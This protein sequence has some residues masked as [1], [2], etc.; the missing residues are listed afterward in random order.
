MR[1]DFDRIEPRRASDSAKWNHY[2][3]DVLPLWVADMDF[4]SPQPIL[5]ALHQRVDHGIFG[6]SHGLDG[7]SELICARMKELQNWEITPQDLLFLPGLVCGLN[8]LCRAVGE[9]G[10]G[11]LVNT[12]VYPPFLTAPENQG[13]V[14]Q[15]ANQR[16]VRRGNN[17]HY[18][19][20]IDALEAAVEPNTRLFILCNPHNPTGRAFTVDELGAIGDLCKRHDLIICS[21]EIHSDLLLGDTRHFAIAAQDAEIAQRTITLLAPSKSWNVPGLGCSIAIIQNP[22][23]RER[24]NQAKA[25]IV[26]HVNLLGYHAA[27]AAYAEGGEWLSQLRRYLTA[28]RDFAV[29]YINTHMPAIHATVPEATYLMW[30]DCRACGFEGDAYQFFLEHAKVALNDGARFGKVGEGFVRLNLGAPRATVAEALARMRHALEALPADGKQLSAA[31][32][33]D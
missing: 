31:A 10:D 5:D 24:F 12:P 3:E 18:E 13:R 27:Y 4:A 16:P 2:G 30:L 7:L 14:L 6:Y 20:D 1:Y 26:P 21:D 19:L 22:A 29:D 17:L 9:A 32:A 15:T 8:V 11:V 23:L 33:D 28:N 25:G